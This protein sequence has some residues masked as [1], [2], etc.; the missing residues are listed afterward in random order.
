MAVVV[1]A[2]A[3][4]AGALFTTAPATAAGYP[5]ST[6]KISYGASYYNGTVTWY[7]RSVGVTGTFRA[8]GCRRVYARAFAGSTSVGFVS[9]STWCDTTAPA[10]LSPP[11]DVVGGADNAWIYMTDANGNYLNGQTCYR[12]S[13]IC[14]DG[15]H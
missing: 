6:F 15:L 13:S 14:I 11:A 1:A 7:N 12:S 9:S 4:V 5:T 8:T 10:P 2:V 3:S